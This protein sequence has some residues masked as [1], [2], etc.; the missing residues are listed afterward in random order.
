MNKINDIFYNMLPTIDL[1]GYDKD[2]AKVATNDFIIENLL[3]DKLKIIII[4]GIGT[5]VVKETVHKTLKQNKNVLK[6][7]ILPT[8][9]GCTI[10]YLQFAKFK[11]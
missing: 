5:G 10:V 8:N 9:I 6:Y 2:S 11:K 3:Q 4:H 1:H 7:E